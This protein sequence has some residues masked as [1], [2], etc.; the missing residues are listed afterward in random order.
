LSASKDSVLILVGSS[1]VLF[2]VRITRTV[3]GFGKMFRDLRLDL[4]QS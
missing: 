2:S 4:F 1:A 3:K